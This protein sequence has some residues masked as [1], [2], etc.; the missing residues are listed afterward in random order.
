MKRLPMLGMCSLVIPVM[1]LL[2]GAYGNVRAQNT[3]PLSTASNRVRLDEPGTTRGIVWWT[4]GTGTVLGADNADGIVL[5]ATVGQGSVGEGSLS[6]SDDAITGSSSTNIG[7]WLPEHPYSSPSSA[8]AL[9]ATRSFELTNHPNPFS[10]ETMIQYR[11]PRSGTVKIV[12]YD[13]AGRQ[14]RALI[15]EERN[16]GSHTAVWNASDDTGSLVSS[17]LYYY[18]LA[19][20]GAADGI[21]M[22]GVM[23]LAR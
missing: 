2:L 9:D 3:E 22:R 16:A 21:V 10:Q 5:S 11:I 18:T 7:Y 19:T 20:D 12:I 1:A 15:D 4:V 23:H 13:A 14:V 8:P 6:W 17:G